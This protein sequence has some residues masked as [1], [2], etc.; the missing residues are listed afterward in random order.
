MVKGPRSNIKVRLEL[1]NHGSRRDLK[2]LRL[3]EKI[4]GNKSLSEERNE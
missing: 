3:T 2:M 1:L 4:G